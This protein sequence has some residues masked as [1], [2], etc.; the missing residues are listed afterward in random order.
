MELGSPEWGEQQ[1]LQGR[2][3]VLA[4]LLNVKKLVRSEVAKVTQARAEVLW[5]IWVYLWGRNLICLNLPWRSNWEWES[6]LW[7]S[8]LSLIAEV[9][10]LQRQMSV[11]WHLLCLPG[12]RCHCVGCHQ[13]EWSLPAER[14]QGCCYS[15]PFLEG[16]EPVG[17]QVSH[18]KCSGQS[19]K[20]PW[21]YLCFRHPRCCSHLCFPS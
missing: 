4:E 20:Q 16:E 19:G 6:V 21:F 9:E 5:F 11:P 8:L 17:H 13:R 12:H 18:I 1:G 10:V 14:T 7:G 3:R 15:S 2:S